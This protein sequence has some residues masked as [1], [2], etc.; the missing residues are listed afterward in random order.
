MPG[1]TIQITG[2]G[3]G[4]AEALRVIEERMQQTAR[5]GNEMSDQL[6]MAGRRIQEVFGAIGIGFGIERV[7]SGLKDL[8]SNSIEAAVQIGHLSQQTGI[9]AENLSVLK[10]AA[11]QTGVEFETFTKG[12]KKLSTEVYNADTGSKKAEKTFRALGVSQA[13][14][15]AKGNDMYAVLS[16]VADKFKEM[17]DG[18]EKNALASQLFGRAGQQLIPV[19]DQGAAGVERFR[20]EAEQ[21]GLVLDDKGIQKMEEL[22]REVD[23]LQSAYKGLGLE[24]T[25]ALAPALETIAKLIPQVFGVGGQGA[26]GNDFSAGIDAMARGLRGLVRDLAEVGLLQEGDFEGARKLEAQWAAQNIAEGQTGRG[27]AVDRLM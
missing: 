27:S 9:S 19:L 26:H 22:H 24:L 8:V 5:R 7:I 2:E 25:S 6:A 12:F 14:L 3:A 10:Y 23:K 16:M 1:I 21:L 11:S 18:I 17:P 4:A 15:T 13:D 20:A